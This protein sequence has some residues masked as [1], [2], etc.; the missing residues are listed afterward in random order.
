M[1]S[2]ALAQDFERRTYTVKVKEGWNL[3]YGDISTDFFGENLVARYRWVNPLNK[4]VLLYPTE[5][6]TKDNKKVYGLTEEDEAILR[7]LESELG[8]LGYYFEDDA[9]WV[10]FSESDTLTYNTNVGS[11]NKVKLFE[12]W[13]IK[14]IMPWMAAPSSKGGKTIDDFKGD[15]IV[16]DVVIYDADKDNWL[17][18]KDEEF[19][20]EMIYGGFAIKVANNC[21]FSFK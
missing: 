11:P 2:A 14:T 4:N 20:D 17:P 16:E 15:C 9:E 19:Y 12:G 10:Y 3:V 1:I 8:Y 18:F 21:E 13:N 7:D 6:I 5:F